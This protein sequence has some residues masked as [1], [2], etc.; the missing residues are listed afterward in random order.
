MGGRPAKYVNNAERHQAFRRRKA[1]AKL[2]SGERTGILCM[3]TGR[4]RKYRNSTEK[5]RAYYLRKK[6]K[7]MIKIQ[8]LCKS[9][10]INVL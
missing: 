3:K 5:N 7:E 9:S 6:A 1:Q 4:I 2:L 10:E 8:E